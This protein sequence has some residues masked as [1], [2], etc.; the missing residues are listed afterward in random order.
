[1][2]MQL[3]IRAMARVFNDRPD[4]GERDFTLR[5]LIGF[6][7]GPNERD[8]RISIGVNEMLQRR[9]REEG[10]HLHP[11]LLINHAKVI[12]R[13]AV[14]ITL[15]DCIAKFKIIWPDFNHV[16]ATIIFFGIMFGVIAP[17]LE[18][19]KGEAQA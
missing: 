5:P 9:R 12:G 17:I 15:A 19:V 14:P 2:T 7:I 8:E 4:R 1:M 16:H 11:G 3:N 10:N 13:D 6:S 18:Q